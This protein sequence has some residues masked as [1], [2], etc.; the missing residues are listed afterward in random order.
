MSYTKQTWT[1]GETITATKLN[2]MEDGI[3]AAGVEY[4]FTSSLT[5]S[6]DS[7]GVS[8]AFYKITP[9]EAVSL[10]VANATKISAYLLN[11]STAYPLIVVYAYTGPGFFSIIV[12]SIYTSVQATTTSTVSGTLHIVAPFQISNVTA[13]M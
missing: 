9:S 13:S 11:G 8:Q 2:H 6:I 10:T 12:K 4:D 1:T 3:E 7:R 5:P